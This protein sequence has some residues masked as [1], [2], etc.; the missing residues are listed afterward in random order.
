MEMVLIAHRAVRTREEKH[1]LD[2]TRD[3]TFS[4][5]YLLFFGLYHI[6]GIF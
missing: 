3:F 1:A 4:S 6:V 2:K 5:F